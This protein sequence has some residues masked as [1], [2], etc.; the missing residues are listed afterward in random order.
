[1][2]PGLPSCYSTESPLPLPAKVLFQGKVGTL[3]GGKIAPMCN[4]FPYLHLVPVDFSPVYFPLLRR[5]R[6]VQKKNPAKIATPP[7]FARLSN[8]PRISFE[9]PLF[10][11]SQLTFTSD[12][13]PDIYPLPPPTFPPISSSP[14]FLFYDWSGSLSLFLGKSWSLPLQS[15]SPTLFCKVLVFCYSPLHWLS[16]QM[17]CIRLWVASLPTSPPPAIQSPDFFLHKGSPSPHALKFSPSPKPDGVEGVSKTPPSSSSPAEHKVVSHP[18]FPT[19][20]EVKK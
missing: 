11:F 8:T 14:V 1:V 6:R 19:H 15:L 10:L 20:R 12:T 18:T 13:Q 5:K 2:C 17:Q 16:S 9:P 3:L 4:V 7:S